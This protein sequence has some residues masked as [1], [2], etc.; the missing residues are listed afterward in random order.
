HGIEPDEVT[1]VTVVQLYKKAGQFQKAEEFFRKRS[2]GEPLRPNNHHMTDALELDERTSFFNA[3][4]GSHTFNTWID[5]YGKAGQLKESSETFVKMLKQG[6]PPTR[7]TFNTMINI[8][9]NHGR[10][11]EASSLL[12]K[13]EELQ[14][15][16][17]T[18][19]YNTLISL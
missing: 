1:M 11:E 8:C 16:P 9:G 10:L 6:I 2:L 14:C 12:Q 17:D 7:V 5:M 19:T 15:S 3:S 4:F 13:M 18:R